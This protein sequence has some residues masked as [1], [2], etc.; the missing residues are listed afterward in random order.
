MLFVIT[1]AFGVGETR[2]LHHQRTCT[3]QM[4]RHA[5]DEIAAQTGKAERPWNTGEPGV[6]PVGEHPYP[7]MQRVRWT[8]WREGDPRCT[9]III[10]TTGTTVR[11]VVDA[12]PARTHADHDGHS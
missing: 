9:S 4:K 2:V 12:I 6:L 11:E 7:T 1:H 5:F 3:F 10:D 8:G